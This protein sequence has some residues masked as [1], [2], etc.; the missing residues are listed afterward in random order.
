[1]TWHAASASQEVRLTT[2]PWQ[3]RSLKRPPG[4][5]RGIDRVSGREIP[6]HSRTFSATM[7]LATDWRIGHSSSSTTLEVIYSFHES[8]DRRK[9]ARHP[10]NLSHV[11][12]NAASNVVFSDRLHRGRIAG[13][14]RRHAIHDQARVGGQR[15]SAWRLF[16]DGAR[17][18]RIAKAGVAPPVFARLSVPVAMGIII[19]R[20]AFAHLRRGQVL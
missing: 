11:R 1:M 14:C 5:G 19:P 16:I 15:T 13:F 8:G 4:G 9:R 18:P 6:P 3:P 10:E 7:V 2:V 20:R 17:L 12:G